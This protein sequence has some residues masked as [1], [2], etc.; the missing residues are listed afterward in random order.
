L[1]IFRRRRRRRF[2]SLSRRGGGFPQA[3][4]C[5]EIA[6]SPRIVRFNA[7]QE[8]ADPSP[9]NRVRDDND[10]GGRV[11]DDNTFL[12]WIAWQ[13]R[14][15]FFDGA[16]EFAGFDE[17]GW[18]GRSKRRPYEEDGKRRGP[19]LKR[20]SHGRGFSR[21]AEALL[22]PHKCGGS[23]RKHSLLALRIG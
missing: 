11:R 17:R 6:N 12:G 18:G 19:A 14:R 4:C 3:K 23:H 22:P 16:N 13:W 15:E 10:L 7:H 1:R 5:R 2:W 20:G 21:S 9:I 8:T